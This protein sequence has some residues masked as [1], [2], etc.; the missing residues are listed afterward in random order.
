MKAAENLKN[1]I[2]NTTAK[3]DVVSMFEGTVTVTAEAGYKILTATITYTDSYGTPM[4]NKE[5]MLSPDGSTAVYISRDMDTEYSITVNGTSEAVGGVTVEVTNSIP[6]TKEEHTYKDGTLTIT[7]TSDSFPSYRFIEPKANYT[8][9]AGTP[10]STA[11]QV[12]V[13]D[14]NSIASATLTDIDPSKPVTIT[15]RF[16]E[17]N[18]IKKKLTNCTD[19]PPL[20][21]WY[22][23]NTSVPVTLVASEGNEFNQDTPPKVTKFNEFGSPETW[24]TL[25]VTPDLKKATGTIVFPSSIVNGVT[26]VGEAVAAA[27]VGKEYGAINVYLVTLDQLNKFAAKRF[28]EAVTTPGGDTQHVEID[29][30]VYVNRIKRIYTDIPS[31]GAA[32]IYCGNYNTGVACEQPAADSVTLDFGGVTLPASNGDSVDYENI[33]QLF[34]PFHGFVN[35]DNSLAGKVI[36]LTYRVNLIT[37]EGAAIITNGDNV[38]QVEEITPSNDVIYQTG[39]QQRTS[40]GGDAWNELAYYGTEPYV[41]ATCY[42]SVDKEGLYSD[43]AKGLVSSFRGRVRFTDI[44]GLNGEGITSH[45]L[46]EIYY[47]LGSGVIIR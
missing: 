28:F 24:Y 20:Q 35:I 36:G 22:P 23:I 21:D 6:N 43:R 42:E 45:E 18:Q 39:A 5:M 13:Q 37:G 32:T 10:T 47:K 46:E 34:L 17:V 26:I 41:L 2:P 25:A 31:G 30:G 8:T 19:N 4:V 15:G 9:S 16:E 12:I 14:Y 7:V 38:I 27:P 3:L 44:Q 29:L 1:N 40:V 33:Y 11:L